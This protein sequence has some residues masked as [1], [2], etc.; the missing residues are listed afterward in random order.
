MRFHL[1]DRIDHY[2]VGRHVKGRKLTS[3][4]EEFWET[5]DE[6]LVMPPSLVLEA[7]CQAGTWLI[8]L[9]TERKRRAALL[10]VDQVEFLAPVRPGAVLMIEGFVD[11][12]NEDVAVLSGTAH[13]DDV[14]VMRAEGIMCALMAADELEEASASELTLKGLIRS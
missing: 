5:G 6:S 8:M 7:L 11:S 3:V 9:S 1:I 10:Q 13:V 14:L 4:S 2:E 12:M